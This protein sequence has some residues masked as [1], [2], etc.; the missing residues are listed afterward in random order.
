MEW[1]ISDFSQLPFSL[2]YSVEDPSEKLDVVNSLIGSCLEKH[3]PLTQIRV[4][5]PPA[6][7]MK[8]LGIRNLQDL[9]FLKFKDDI[10]KAMKRREITLA[11]FAGYSKAFDTVDFRLLI[12]KLHNLNFSKW[13]LYW[14]T[15]YLTNRR[16]YV[17]INDKLSNNTMTSFGVPQG[18][19]F[20]PVLFNLYV[21]DMQS[22]SNVQDTCLQYADYSTIYQP[23]RVN[24]L[25]KCK[26][27]LEDTFV[28]YQYLVNKH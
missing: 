7:W 28:A 9:F 15:S 19:I 23:Y 1:F 10:T 25:W 5:R 2:V 14:L 4:T 6:A 17:Q 22:N 16:Q 11:V 24:E 8:D 21:A 13:F 12:N 3:A 18:S 20:G 26:S 27:T